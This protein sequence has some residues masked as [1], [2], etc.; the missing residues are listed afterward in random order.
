MVRCCFRNIFIAN[1]DGHFRFENY[2]PRDRIIVDVEMV[3][4]AGHSLKPIAIISIGLATLGSASSAEAVSVAA[5]MTRTA[6][7]RLR[8]KVR[9]SARMRSTPALRIAMRDVSAALDPAITTGRE[10]EAYGQAP[11]ARFAPMSR[12]PGVP[13]PGSCLYTSSRQPVHRT[14]V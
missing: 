3:T 12:R 8:L 5:P 4:P 14:P 1:C 11:R 10:R 13:E 2:L 9:D 6:R 7:R